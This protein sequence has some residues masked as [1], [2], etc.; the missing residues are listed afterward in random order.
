MC[1]LLLGTFDYSKNVLLQRLEILHEQK[2]AQKPNQDPLG[3]LID[4]GD[5]ASMIDKILERYFQRISRLELNL[6]PV[7]C[8]YLSW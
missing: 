2:V 7:H 5:R 3:P 1:L 6:P 8:S 4:Q